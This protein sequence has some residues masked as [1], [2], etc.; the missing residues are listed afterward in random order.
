MQHLSNRS[1]F[2]IPAA[3][4]YLS[5]LTEIFW[6]DSNRLQQTPQRI[7]FTVV[8]ASCLLSTA[9][10]VLLNDDRIIECLNT[11][12]REANTWE[13]PVSLA[14][15]WLKRHSGG[16][17]NNATLKV[18]HGSCY[19]TKLLLVRSCEILHKVCNLCPW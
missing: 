7:D 5:P 12:L 8:R 10:V 15:K 6:D 18:R 16:P 9:T 2:D 17:I 13:G 14:R 11:T 4:L 3:P 1:T 19:S